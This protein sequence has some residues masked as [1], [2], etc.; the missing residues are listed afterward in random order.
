LIPL[1]L[2][3]V[4]PPEGWG[5]FLLL[6]ATVLSLLAAVVVAEWVPGDEWLL[7]LALVALL[8]GRWLARQGDWG[9]SVWLPVGVTL[10]F[11][12]ALSVAAHVVLFWPGSGEAAF[13][14]AQRW[15]IWLQAAVS[16]GTSEDPDIFLFYVSLLCWAGV[17]LSA[18]AFYRRR[19]PMLALLPPALLS[20]V[21]IFYSG[22]GL[23]WLIGGLGCGVLMLAVGTL[24]LEQRTWEATGV[25]YASGLGFE[26][27]VAAC[28]IAV[29]VV[30]I[31]M[32]GPLLTVRNVSDWFRR[33]FEQPAARVEDTAERLFGGVSPPEG[34][35][36]GGEGGTGIGASSYLPESRLLGGRPD[37]LDQVVIVVWTDEPPPAPADY[38]AEAREA[39]SH[40]W[41]GATMDYYSGQGWATTVYTRQVVEGELP[42][43]TPPDYR[44]VTQRFTFVAPHGNT[45]YALNAPAWIGAPVEALW[46]I[47]PAI[48]STRGEAVDLARLASEV[49]SYTV[50]SRLP[51]PTAGDL[52]AVPPLYPPEIVERYLQLPDMLPQRVVDLAW[53]IAGDGQTV[54]ERARLLERYLRTYPY[55]LEVGRL[56]EDRDVADYFLFDLREGYCD[57]Y[58]TAFVVMARTVGIPARLASGYVGGQ[59]DYGA[60]GYLVHD[61]SGH[62]WPQVYFPGWGWIGFEPTTAQAVTELPAESPLPEET[63]PRSIA[64]PA[65][66]VRRRWLAAGLG[67]AAVAGLC[68][69]GA[70]WFRRRRRRAAQVVTLPLVW[71]WVGQGG[72]RVG[73]CPD[74]ALT[75]QE[76]ATALAAEL[77][78]RAQR[79]RRWNA[80]WTELAA[81]GGAAL[82]R[83]AALYSLQVYGGTH[84]AMV[85][86]ATARNM[87]TR[88]RKP[89]RWF[90]WL[91]CLYRAGEWLRRKTET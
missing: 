68:W 3:R 15:A 38:P 87:W 72:T 2:Q 29:P 21:S 65:R 34:P 32:F 69:A 46:R 88:L 50:V 36:A 4:R 17:L 81:E 84:T 14:F 37:L 40:Y 52:R 44:E 57:Y 70:V 19:R 91:R 55:S 78:A 53:D 25:D 63:L 41:V 30:L 59:Y 11:L 42:L 16:G 67:V 31:S 23:M 80:R 13:D 83:L 43:P 9:W 45:L 79:T 7:P 89:L 26:V 76:Y 39:P 28:V 77:R 6:A 27:L 48:P 8:I 18:W 82:R 33:T 49:V 85:D 90:R 47:P 5:T 62:S 60:G 10:G 54:Y 35:A 61:R 51:A 66:V 20:A 73:L 24:A 74:L 64:P 12:A 58:A 1:L 71:S 22:R 75:P 86:Q 56:P